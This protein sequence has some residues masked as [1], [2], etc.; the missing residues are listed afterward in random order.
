MPAFDK[1]EVNVNVSPVNASFALAKADMCERM[2]IDSDRI[3]LDAGDD[4]EG[5]GRCDT[6]VSNFHHVPRVRTAWSANAIN[7]FSFGHSRI[8]CCNMT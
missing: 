2:A 8:F 4:E 5:S 6:Q 1:I 7:P 3:V